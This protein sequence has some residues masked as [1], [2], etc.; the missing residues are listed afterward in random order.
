MVFPEYDGSVSMS[1]SNI[2]IWKAAVGS[3]HEALVVGLKSEN[4]FRHQCPKYS[5]R[6]ADLG[7]VSAKNARHCSHIMYIH[8]VMHPSSVCV[9]HIIIA[10]SVV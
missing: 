8:V 2:L 3:L 9:I 4:D 7:A 6:L 5:C 10:I 1:K